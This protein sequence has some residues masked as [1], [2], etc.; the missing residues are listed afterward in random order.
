MILY[1]IVAKARI[2][3]T[4]S[5]A[6]YR[7]SNEFFENVFQDAIE[8]IY[9]YDITKFYD[10]YG[11]VKKLDSYFYTDPHIES[12]TYALNDL[13]HNDDNEIFQV[14]TPGITNATKPSEWNLGYEQTTTDGTVVFTNIERCDIP[15]PQSHL[16]PLTGF[17]VAKAYEIDSTDQTNLQLSQKFME[18]YRWILN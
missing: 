8:E 11:R 14:T 7:W 5:V 9:G 12:N 10:S 3:L 18:D 17:L 13:I 2:L 15:F 16:R 6:P 1:D 4:D